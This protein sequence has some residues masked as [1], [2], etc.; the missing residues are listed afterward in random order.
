MCQECV[1]VFYVQTTA[2]CQ[3]AGTLAKPSDG[4]EPST[5]PYHALLL[6]TGR[7]P[8]QRFWLV[9][10]LALLHDLPLIATS[11]NHEAP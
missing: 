3:F 4:L 5:P 2:K 1:R 10:R 8:P 11:C 9:P 7:N 6:A